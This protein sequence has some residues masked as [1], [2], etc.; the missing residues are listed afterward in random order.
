VQLRLEE[1]ARGQVNLR[2]M[3][4]MFLRAIPSERKARFENREAV[5]IALVNLDSEREEARRLRP[6]LS[7]AAVQDGWAFALLRIHGELVHAASE[8]I[9]NLPEYT[10]DMAYCIAL[11]P[12]A[13]SLFEQGRYEEALPLY[14]ELHVLRWARPSA[15]LD[16]AVSFL[17]LGDSESAARL[18]YETV[19]ELSEAMDDV[20]L[21]RAGDILLGAGGDDRAEQVFRM[22]IARLWQEY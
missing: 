21:E 22:A 11:Y 6:D 13:R 1:M 15:Y 5:A 2:A 18:A 9:Y 3:H 7:I 19:T 8:E 14:L 17:R 16:A 20:L 10:L 12:K 4:L